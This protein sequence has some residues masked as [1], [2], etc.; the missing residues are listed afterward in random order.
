MVVKL[1]INLFRYRAIYAYRPQNDDELEL[2][3]GDEV[4][5]MEK[6]DDGWFVGTSNRTGMFGTFPGNYVQIIQCEF[7]SLFTSLYAE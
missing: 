2:L 7:M 1:S 4:F 5:V 6:C 3:E